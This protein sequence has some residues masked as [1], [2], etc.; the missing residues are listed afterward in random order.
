[1][2]LEQSRTAIGAVGELLRSRLTAHTSAGSVD[3]GRPEVAA[4][5]AGPKFN[6]FLYQVELDA[7]LRNQALDEG[8]STPLWLV[9]RYLITAYDEGRESDSVAAHELLGAGMLALQELNFLQPD[10]VPALA[11]NPQ[12]L[13]ITFDN[14]DVDL[15]S[16][17]MQGTDE[18]YR[19]SAAFQVRPVLIAPSEPPA[20]AP[21]VATVG[22][23]GDEGVDVIPGMGPRLTS[24]EPEQFQI[25]DTVTVYGE[26]L[27]SVIEEL[28]I[29][30]QCYDITAAPE[31][32]VQTVIP[33]DTELSPGSHVILAVRT[34]P[35]GTRMCSNALLG[36]LMPTLQI[37]VV[38][39]LSADMA[40]NLSGL[41]T[42]TG[43][44]LGG[45]DDTIFVAFYRD[46]AVQ[47]MLEGV[48]VVAQNSVSVT[49][50]V[51]D[52]LAPGNYRIFL[53]V[54]GA[55]APASPE[56]NWS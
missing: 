27:G 46:G 29:G 12:S 53:R 49:V 17:L 2:P 34:S 14:A 7:F 38:G 3:V 36:T 32:R 48:G 50:P 6:L 11:D 16:K 47:L 9:L 8:Q 24:V 28:C 42:L 21:L 26:D 54:N 13:K 19:V 31:G 22:P 56:V 35:R 52:A 10:T 51:D 39:A 37:A 55:Q 41:I 30:D 20:Y 15:L 40:G 45:P 25:G 5:S 43:E 1:M 18:R 23:S 33:A 4:G 44:R